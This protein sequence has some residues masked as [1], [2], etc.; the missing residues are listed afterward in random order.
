M[1]LQFRYIQRSIRHGSTHS[2]ITSLNVQTCEPLP[3]C[4]VTG[5][6][7]EITP[8]HISTANHV[9]ILKQEKIKHAMTVLTKF[10]T[11]IQ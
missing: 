3:Q 2:H 9:H 11:A 6:K 5:L 4:Y 7:N 1:Y 8:T 10:Y